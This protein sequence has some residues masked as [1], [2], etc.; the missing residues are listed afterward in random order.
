MLQFCVAGTAAPV[1]QCITRSVRDELAEAKATEDNA[2][3]CQFT[4]H[5]RPLLTSFRRSI[6]FNLELTKSRL[7]SRL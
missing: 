1:W 5:A 6:G 2:I 4:R 7:V 3:T